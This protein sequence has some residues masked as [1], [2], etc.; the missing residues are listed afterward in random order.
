MHRVP[1]TVTINC[2]VDLG[3]NVG[4]DEKF[5]KTCKLLY[6]HTGWSKKSKPPKK[7]Q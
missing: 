4:H 7:N 2:I 3:N 5:D 1:F 6:K